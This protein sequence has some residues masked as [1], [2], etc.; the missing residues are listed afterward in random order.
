[1]QPR[2]ADVQS[3]ISS[4]ALSVGPV[5]AVIIAALFIIFGA[6]VIAFPDLL[7]WVVGI[8]LIVAGIAVLASALT[9]GNRAG[10][11]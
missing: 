8:G 6:L 5:I 4:A 9:A 2:L 1:M 7:S 3:R 10:W 11:S